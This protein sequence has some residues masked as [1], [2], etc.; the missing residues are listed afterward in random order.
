MRKTTPEQAAAAAPDPGPA[1]APADA[2]L[3]AAPADAA[4]A[5]AP[6]DAALAAAPADAAPAAAPGI[7]RL[8]EEWI[9]LWQEEITALAAD[10]DLAALWRQAMAAGGGLMAMA[11]ASGRRHDRPPGTAAPGAAPGAGGAAAGGDAGQPAA[12]AGGTGA[13]AG[14]GAGDAAALW[15]RIDGLERRL[16]ALEAGPGGDGADRRGPRRRRPPA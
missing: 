12:G 16:A 11:P 13:G 4:L 5:A 8:A 2:A 10:P 9:G 6:A 15:A 1:S 7:D 3:A 14:A